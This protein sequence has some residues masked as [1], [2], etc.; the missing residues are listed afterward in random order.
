M[1]HRTLERVFHE[2]Y[3]HLKVVLKNLA[4][5]RFFNLLLSV[6]TSDETHLLVFDILHQGFFVVVV[7]AGKHVKKKKMPS[8]KQRHQGNRHVIINIIYNSLPARQ[9]VIP[10]F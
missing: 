8:L 1:L 3:K 2:I 10:F 5:P 6:W 4:A 7:V 9:T